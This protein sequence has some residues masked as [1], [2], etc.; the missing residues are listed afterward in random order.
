MNLDTPASRARYWRDTERRRKAWIVRE[1]NKAA[2]RFD[3]EGQYITHLFVF[4]GMAAALMGITAQTDHW[5]AYL[6]SLYLVVAGDFA[7]RF[8]DSVSPSVPTDSEAERSRRDQQSGALLHSALL[9]WLFN[10]SPKKA[11]EITDTSREEIESALNEGVAA[12]EAK[13]QLA[14]RITN[15]YQRWSRVRSR[16][17]AQTEVVAASN[18]GT[19]EAARTTVATLNLTLS[20]VWVAVQD[21]RT[22]PW[23]R[24]AD[25]QK[26]GLD[27][28]FLVEGEELQ[29]PGDWAHGASPDNLINCRCTVGYQVASAAQR[30]AA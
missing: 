26:R 16:T 28:Y 22:R 10:Q 3:E 20:K 27:E 21:N 1:T 5:N 19:H 6:T 7:D 24:A 15:Q 4:A 17:I 18:L 30:R 14:A 13:P 29:Y 11:R 9:A 25:G 12:G 2:R 23:H 8:F